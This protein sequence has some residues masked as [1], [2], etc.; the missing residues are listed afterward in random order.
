MPIT[1]T[2]HVHYTGIIRCS[3][4]FVQQMQFAPYMG[5]GVVVHPELFWRYINCLIAYLQHPLC[6]Q[7]CQYSWIF[8][9]IP[10]Q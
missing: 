6:C 2:V 5:S 1:A 9:N 3:T 7:Y 8:A 4:N 10:F